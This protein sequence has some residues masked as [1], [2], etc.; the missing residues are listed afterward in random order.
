VL[1]ASLAMGAGGIGCDTDRP[2]SYGRQ[3]PPVDELDPRDRGLQSSDVLKAS[4]EIAASLLSL[5]ELRNSDRRWSMVVTNVEDL[6]RDRKFS[7]I[8]YNIFIE[9][10]RSNLARQG[11]SQIRLIEN[12]DRFY[13]VRNRELE[14]EREPGDEFGEGQG[15]GP[16]GAPQAT[17]PDFG[18]YAKAMD[19]PNRGT[20][21]YL[22][23]F[24]VT[25]LRTREQ[26]FIDDYEVRVARER[27]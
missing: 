17:S 19:L 9:R 13:D 21:Y 8:D 7:G 14:A 4:D 27:P 1:F 22:I 6:T 26:V 16:G 23:Q 25:D 18:L 5:P 15:G 24:V 12:R 3:R 20:T 11:R 2:T 10:L